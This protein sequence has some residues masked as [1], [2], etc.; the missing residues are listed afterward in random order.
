M[1]IARSNGSFYYCVKRLLYTISHS[2]LSIEHKRTKSIRKD[3]VSSRFPHSVRV[4]K[5]KKT[6]STYRSQSRQRS[7]R[8]S[9]EHRRTVPFGSIRA[10]VRVV[11]WDRRSQS[12]STIAVHGMVSLNKNKKKKSQK[13]LEADAGP[14]FTSQVAN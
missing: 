9:N 6:V 12:T 10:N 7:E 13:P 2:F 4:E 11:A 5:K 14:H 3:G 8:R 1:Y